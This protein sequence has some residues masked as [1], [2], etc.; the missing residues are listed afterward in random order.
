MMWLRQQIRQ[1]HSASRRRM[2][3]RPKQDLVLQVC[4]EG[5][6]TGRLSIHTLTLFRREVL[7]PPPAWIDRPAAEERGATPTVLVP[8]PIPIPMPIPIPTAGE[9]E[10][11]GMLG[12]GPGSAPGERRCI[13]RE[14]PGAFIILD[15]PSASDPKC[16]TVRHQS[17]AGFRLRLGFGL[18]L[19]FSSSPRSVRT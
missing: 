9:M 12:G 16:W 19:F 3:P 7:P 14:G 2:K 4:R 17:R 13:E 10:R 5:M 15:W 18:E 11:A 6:E 8:T 1:I